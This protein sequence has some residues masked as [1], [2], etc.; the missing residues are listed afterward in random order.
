VVDRPARLEVRDEIHDQVC[1]RL[2]AVANDVGLYAEEYDPL[3]PRLL[4]NFPQ[5]FTHPALV[6][7]AHTLEPDQFAMARRRRDRGTTR[8]RGAD[9]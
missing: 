2:L 8:A 9:E 7:A 3:V 5:A 1:E 6:A 4:G